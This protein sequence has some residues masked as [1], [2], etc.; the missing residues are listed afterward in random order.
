MQFDAVFLLI[1]MIFGVYTKPMDRSIGDSI[2]RIDHGSIE[3]RNSDGDTTLTLANVTVQN[4]EGSTTV[5]PGFLTWLLAPLS[6]INPQSLLQN[7]VLQLKET[8]NNLGLKTRQD[9]KA[10]QLTGGN[11]LLHVEGI[12]EPGFYANRLEPA[13]FFDGNNGWVES[14]GGIPAASGTILST[15]SL[16]TDYPVAYRRK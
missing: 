2:N 12:N 1:L 4:S 16:L 10:R 7:G 9:I 3:L 14:K 13:G 8:L 15:G 5:K 11:N 6:Q